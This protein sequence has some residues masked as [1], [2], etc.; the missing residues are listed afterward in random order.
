MRIDDQHLAGLNPAA[1][2]ASQQVNPA[3][4]NS[5]DG[6]A[7][8]ASSINDDVQL[9]SLAG[10]VGDSDVSSAERSARIAQ[11]TKV[12]QSGQYNPDPGKIADAIIG[13]MTSSA[14]SAK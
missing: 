14:P 8:G 5:A 11:L 3:S 4:K 7:K 1:T 10:K 13:E 9:S 12:V 2:G 6:A